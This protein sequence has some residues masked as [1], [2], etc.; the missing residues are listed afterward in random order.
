MRSPLVNAIH[1]FVSLPCAL[2][3]FLHLGNAGCTLTGDSQRTLCGTLSYVSPEM[4]LGQPHGP[5]VDI[6][7][8]NGF[9]RLAFKPLHSEH[10]CDF[11]SFVCGS[12]A[13]IRRL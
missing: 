7:V 10:C 2:N 9:T 6:W 13:D 4:I 1:R 8:R 12:T 5:G 11:V 3:H